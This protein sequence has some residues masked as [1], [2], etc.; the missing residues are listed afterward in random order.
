MKKAETLK[1]KLVAEF[2][3][4]QDD[5]VQAYERVH[6]TKIPRLED[7]L[8]EKSWRQILDRNFGEYSMRIFSSDIPH[9]FY[10]FVLNS[11][12]ATCGSGA[13]VGEI[14]KSLQEQIVNSS[15]RY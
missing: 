1:K 15:K 2:P 14:T 5:V 13:T 4:I 6:Q 8:A 12:G 10:F 9:L 3:K 11:G 7:I